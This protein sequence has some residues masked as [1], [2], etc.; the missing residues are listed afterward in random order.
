[1]TASGIARA[2]VMVAVLAALVAGCG[3]NLNA[4][5]GAVGSS[6]TKA[7]PGSDLPADAG[8]MEVE[9]P[10]PRLV[11]SYAD[12]D[13]LDVL[14]L[15]SGESV[16]SFEVGHSAQL[17]AIGGRFAFAAVR[18][19]GQVHV[20][21]VGSWSIDHGDHSHSYI[22][23]PAALGVLEGANPARIV[24]RDGK[25]AVVF[26]GDSLD[27]DSSVKT[28][29][30]SD[31]RK[32]AL[33]VV[34]SVT[35]DAERDGVAIEQGSE[36]LPHVCPNGRGTS[37]LG[38]DVVGV[39]DDAIMLFDKSS[40][41]RT[42]IATPDRVVAVNLSGDGNHVLSMLA[43]GTFRVY[44]A[45]TGTETASTRV[46]A[47]PVD[48][49]EKDLPAPVI[50]VGGNRAYVSDAAR[51]TVLEIDYRDSARLARTFDVDGAPSSLMVA[52]W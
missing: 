15:E 24:A 7:L 47:H 31:L 40:H 28:V 34:A 16:A 4:D 6:A 8:S 33:N 38:E 44:D 37:G 27:G 30:I 43:D 41:E 52:G 23:A 42:Q 20:I 39:C 9:G 48:W 49:D 36:E 5:E 3:S 11:V 22:K 29:E 12:S 14:D 32:G 10:A 2:S 18:D 46:L 51:G 13:A 17:T 19:A 45:A 35:A 1:M 21:D 26:D 25:V 50:V